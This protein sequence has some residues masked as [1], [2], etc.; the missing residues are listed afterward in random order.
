MATT[1]EESLPL[2]VGTLTDHA[3]NQGSRGTL[4]WTRGDQEPVAT[5][6]YRYLTGED[7]FRLSYTVD[8]PYR[9]EP[10]D[11]ELTIPLEYTP[12]NLGGERPWFSCPDCGTRRAKLYKPPAHD[13]FLCRE[14]HDLLYDSQTYTSKFVEPFDRM[15]Q[16][17]EEIES[18][19]VSRDTL[20]RF[21]EAQ[22]D[23]FEELNEQRRALEYVD[24]EELE[25]SHPDSF[26]E[27]LLRLFEDLFGPRYGEYGRCEATAR[28]TG[29]RCWQPATGEHG[30]CYYHGGAEGSGISSSDPV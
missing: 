26:E 14:C 8:R 12:A 2:D 10:K 9:S 1:V 29:S 21:Y 5:V 28:S 13:R 16:L 22:T 3:S 20:R 7:V 27:W 25:I 19:G 4:T 24:A 6:G 17:V 15:G 23:I 11:I 30:K 18:E